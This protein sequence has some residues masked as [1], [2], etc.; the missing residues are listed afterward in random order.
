[1]RDIFQGF[2]L[3]FGMLSTLPFIKVH[4]FYKGINGYGVMFYP[5]V[6][7]LLG[8]IL[9][10]SYT[11]LSNFFP[12]LHVSIMVLALWVVIT[13]ALHLDGFSDTIDGLFVSKQRSFEVMKDPNIGAMGMI[14]TLIMILLKASALLHVSDFFEL[15]F[16]LMLAR[17]NSVLAIYLYPYLSKNG[18]GALAKEEFGSKELFFSTLM[19]LAVLFFS[20]NAL[21]LL[22]ISLI[23]LYLLKLFFIKRYGGFTGD[24]YGFVIEFSELVLLH[25]IILL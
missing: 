8:V 12:P 7:A 4:T 11:F 10:L 9:A 20:T 2:A 6:G 19:V 25:V 23:N 5:L 24:I 1:M 13:G 21:L 15:I 18:M 16:I 14:F 22:S 3:A 17:Y